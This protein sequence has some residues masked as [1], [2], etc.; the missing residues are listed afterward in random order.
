MACGFP[1]CG[2]VDCADCHKQP[3]ASDADLDYPQG[4]RPKI[5]PAG[6]AHLMKYALGRNLTDAE[7]WSL[8][9]PDSDDRARLP[10][11]PACKC[12]GWSPQEIGVGICQQC[13]RRITR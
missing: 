3:S 6:E 5:S 1:Y 8:G 11:A 12:G 2:G 9:L 10:G 13:G 4:P 7:C